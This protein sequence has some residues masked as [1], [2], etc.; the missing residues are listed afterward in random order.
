[1]TRSASGTRA[2]P[3]VH[4]SQKAALNRAVLD[5]L[6]GERRRQL[7]YKCPA[8]GSDL[9]LVHP[10]RTSQTCGVCHLWDPAS[11]VSRD[12]FICTGCG[13]TD[14]ADHNAS[15][16][17]LRRALRGP[18]GTTSAAGHCGEQ[19]A[20]AGHARPAMPRTRAGRTR[21]PLNPSSGTARLPVDI[22]GYKE[23]QQVTAGRMSRKNRVSGHGRGTSK[24]TP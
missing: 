17:I 14:D 23:S 9:S 22:E 6:P 24:L 18:A 11:R 12:R 10:A 2:A 19:H 4:V 20:P 13:H 1:M 3:G 15:V 21:E 7:V 16:V 8:Y 5:N